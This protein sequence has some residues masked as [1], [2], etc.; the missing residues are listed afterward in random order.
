MVPIEVMPMGSAE[1]AGLPKLVEGNAAVS[2]NTASSSDSVVRPLDDGG[3]V[4]QAIRDETAPESYSYRVTLGEEQ[5]LRSIDG[6]HAEV[7]YS[8]HE[9]AFSITAEPAHDAV[10][11]AVPTTLTVDGRDVVTLHVSYKT[12]STGPPFV[13]PITAGTGWQ[14][15]FRTISVEM[16]NKKAE[17]GEEEEGSVGST[18][19]KTIVR[20]SALSAPAA[21]TSS[22]QFPPRKYKITQC[23]YPPFGLELPPH[24]PFPEQHREQLISVLGG[25][26]DPGA[27]GEL[28]AAIGIWGEF[29]YQNG[30]GV[31]VNDSEPAHCV[32][33]REGHH[34][35]EVVHCGVQPK[36][37]KTA[38]TVRGDFKWPQSTLY[39]AG[40]ACETMYAHLN[41]SAPHKEIMPDIY[42]EL[43]LGG[44][45]DPCP[46]PAWPH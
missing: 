8:G 44:V 16:D 23:E 25:C 3:M 6:Q 21:S 11:T 5:V 17:P 39:P 38:I 43:G 1:E 36:S 9:P 12:G 26:K 40:P 19:S 4:F 10:G 20:I 14:G 22:V 42:H 45:G 30:Q 18:A 32:K 31:W 33:W 35:P 13:Y 41:A 2:A 37:S 7:Y 34:E 28:I 15:G 46:W 27:N 24:E 29:H